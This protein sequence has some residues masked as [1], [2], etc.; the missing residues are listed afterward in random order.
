MPD[1]VTHFYFSQQV[2]GA[3]APQIS[4][5]LDTAIFHHA[6]A[7]PDVWFSCGFYGGGHKALADRGNHMHETRTGDFLTALA[8]QARASSCRDGLF[9]YLAGFLCHYC[10]DCSTHPYIIS[11]T[12]TYDGTPETLPYRGN[13]M[14]LE[15]AV[16]CHIIRTR[17]GVAPSRFPINRRVLRLRRLPEEL[18]WDLDAVYAGIY[19]WPEAWRDLN[20]AIADQ[21]R[22]YALV[23]DPTGL[24]NRA[25]GW[26]DDGKSP[27]DYR[28]VSY[29]GRDLDEA[30][31]DYLNRSQR[32]WRHPADTS[33]TSR[34]S[35]PQL[36]QQAEEEAA[37]LVEA[38]WRYI[39]RL[40]EGELLRLVGNRS[41]TTGFDCRDPRNGGPFCFDPLF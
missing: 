10:L 26:L 4:S 20:T 23:Q 25:A 6:A 30:Q 7:G 8:R 17:Y 12:G 16:D 35:F 28:V 38:S 5:C 32:L 29:H 15:R 9:S 33:L 1:L 40:E 27:Y 13:H 3:L 11:Q 36:F 18:R 24:V 22:F 14:R 31:V 37:R 41:Y 34:S 2:C 21:R 19:G 39:Y